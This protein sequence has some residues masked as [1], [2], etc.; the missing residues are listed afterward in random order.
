MV[1]KSKGQKRNQIL[2]DS[3]AGAV[4]EVELR[5]LKR[6]A[7]KFLKTLKISNAELSLTLVRDREIKR[8]NS[9]WR[10][11]NKPTDVLSFPAGESPVVGL[12]P[13]GDIIISVETATRAAGEFET[14][15]RRELNLYL[16]HGLLHL[17]GHDH[18]TPVEAR[19]M[20]RLEAKLLGGEGMLH[21]SDELTV[22]PSRRAR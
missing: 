10:G 22:L 11:K 15:L 4:G 9:E 14:S 1:T 17:L 12:K 3:R 6:L 13:L 2:A 16:A 7:S 8:I 20:A 21:R 5:R 19:T 18:H